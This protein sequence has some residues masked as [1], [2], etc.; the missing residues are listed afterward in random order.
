MSNMI[1]DQ[2]TI[3]RIM[4]VIFAAVG[5]IFLIVGTTIYNSIKKRQ[6]RCTE[7]ASASVVSYEESVRKTKTKSGKHSFTKKT[8]VYTPV[9]EFSVGG[10]SYTG[11]SDTSSSTKPFE[12]GAEIQ[13]HYEPGDPSNNYLNPVSPVI[14]YASFAGGGVF[15]LIG[16]LGIAGKLEGKRKR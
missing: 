2:K 3:S 7:T 15:M 14:K 5:V 6:D 8:T 13:I 1:T 11:K 16:I 4:G 9:Y 12:I 10:A